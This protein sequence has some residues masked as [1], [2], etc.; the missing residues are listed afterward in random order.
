MTVRTFAI[1]AFAAS[2]A[3]WFIWT[4]IVMWL[5][6][7]QAGWIG[8]ALFFL[9]LFLAVAGTT[10]LG[11]YIMRRLLMPGQLP[12]YSVRSALRQGVLLGL[13][14]DVLLALQLFRLV[15]WW[16]TVIA[17]IL[18]LS[19]ELL[20]LSYERSGRKAQSDRDSST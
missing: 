8:F 7:T 4:L 9:S 6:P 10:A 13:F 17:I 20:F 3:S 5:D 1:G 14:L 12:A 15:R 16:V 18:F 11:G 2:L 19:I